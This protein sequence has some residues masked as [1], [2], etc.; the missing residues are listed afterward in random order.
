MPALANKEGRRRL[1]FLSER[2]SVVSCMFGLVVS[3]GWLGMEYLEPDIALT[4]L[5]ALV[6]IGGGAPGR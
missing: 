6:G 5:V 1:G 4:R 2:P 3:G